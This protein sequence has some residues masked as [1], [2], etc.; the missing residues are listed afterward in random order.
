MDITNYYFDILDDFKK[1]QEISPVAK[2]KVKG[3]ELIKYPCHLFLDQATST[4][5]AIVDDKR[6]LVRAGLIKKGYKDSLEDYKFGLKDEIL[7]LISEYKIND[8]WHEETYDKANHW[9]TEVLLYIKHMIKDLAYESGGDIRVFGLDHMKWKT[10]LAKP[11]KFK[12]T[13]SGDDK[14]EVKKLVNLVYPLLNLPE[15]TT[16]ALGM[17]IAIVWKQTAR[18]SYYNARINKKLPV[19]VEVFTLKVD[20]DIEEKIK[21]MGVR[22]TRKY[23]LGGVFE[24]E[25]VD[26]YDEALNCRY[27]LS[28]KDCVCYAKIPF[29]RN[30]GMIMLHYGI[31]PSKLEEGEEVIVM[32]SRKK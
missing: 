5:F 11:G 12:R 18:S 14:K 24:F 28:F 21:K 7:S 20:E 32:A 19:N 16:D 17:A 6:R 1:T 25:Y 2:E 23:D 31:I 10:L 9:T 22:F 4:G 26:S 27:I 3:N 8:V 13:K 15:D 29:H 30:L